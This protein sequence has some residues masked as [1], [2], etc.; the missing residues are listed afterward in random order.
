MRN[1]SEAAGKGRVPEINLTGI[2]AKS[3][4][5][6]RKV[7]VSAT[8]PSDKPC[9]AGKPETADMQKSA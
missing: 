8:T 4:Q 9:K 5:K 3:K 7:S 6:D 1:T 2:Q